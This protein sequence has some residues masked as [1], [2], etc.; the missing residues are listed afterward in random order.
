MS[1][2]ESVSGDG[3]AV[4][5][6]VDENPSER[7]ETTDRSV[8]WG[9]T[10]SNWS[11]LQSI[12]FGGLLGL[13][14]GVVPVI[15]TRL[16]AIVDEWLSVDILGSIGVLLLV[17][18]PLAVR[19]W[20]WA[21]ETSDSNP[22]SVGDQLEWSWIRPLWV[23]VGV[24][25]GGAAIW[26]VDDV[27]TGMYT[28]QMALVFLSLM[29]QNNWQITTTVEPENGVIETE[30]PTY[31]KRRSVESA[32]KIRRFDLRN[33]S[34]FVFSNRGKRW[35]KGPHLLSVPAE[36]APEV[37]PL[38]REMV[39]RAD[40]PP[41]ISRDERIVI[42]SVGASMLGIGPLLYLLSGEGALLLVAAGPSAI[43]AHFALMHAHRG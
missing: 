23:G 29:F 36:L 16:P 17:F 31:T 15:L 33:R 34:L 21:D 1:S 6:P 4:E 22:H 25:A 40:S 20:N 5:H 38:I 12:G 42:G 18:G 14:G 3:T 30:R 13:A 8:S 35:Y 37:E 43:V 10:Q 27:L 11:W 41:R 9:A 32:V 39:D 2:V 26:M 24:I 28:I 19:T 7:S